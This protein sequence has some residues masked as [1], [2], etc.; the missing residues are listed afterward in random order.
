MLFGRSGW[1]LPVLPDGWNLY[2]L[3]GI[4][5]A[6]IYLNMPFAIRMLR[7]QYNNIPDPAWRLAQQLKLSAWQRFTC[8]ELPVLRP[9]LVMLL[10]FVFI[11]CFNSFAV[12]L[13]LGGGPQATTLEVAIYQALKYDFN[14]PEAL[15]L[16]WT[17]LVIA[18]G[19]F[20]VLYRKGSGGWL[21]VDLPASL[22]RPK[23]G[24]WASR[25]YRC[26]YISVWVFLTLPLISLAF[27]AARNDL[28]S[29]DYL[30]LLQPVLLSVLLGGTAATLA[31]VIGYLLLLP[32]REARYRGMTRRQWL[33][34]WLA[35][36]AL[37]APAMVTSVGLY[38]LLLPR[39]DLDGYGLGLV[40]LLNTLAVVPFVVQQLRPRLLQYDAQYDLL[41]RNL[42][43]SPLMRL[44]VELPYMQQVLINAFALGLLLAIGDVS[45]FA[46]FGHQEFITLPWLI[47]SYAGTY[48][49]DEAALASLVLLLMC[50]GLM[51]L[52]VVQ[53]LPYKSTD[54]R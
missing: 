28:L 8:I 30:A 10:G 47:Y 46:I 32:V 37:I 48:R 51:K 50:A 12:V 15:S 4:L 19:L 14:I 9:V 44:R 33:V 5:L 49:M 22:W 38:V 17:Q 35:T 18:G 25:L 40:A 7:Q 6:H 31:V 53:K 26:G 42:K 1:L 52:F 2:G 20:V 13:A 23:P 16:A 41:V 45:V 11:L 54:K 29:F 34:E 39:I 43:F 3:H 24:R 36:H 21:S 27:Q